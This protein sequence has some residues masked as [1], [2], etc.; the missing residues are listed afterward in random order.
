MHSTAQHNTAQPS[1]AQ[2]SPAQHQRQ[3][4]RGGS[5]VL[6]G[7]G[8]KV[9]L[10][11]VAQ[12]VDGPM[13][14]G[15]PRGRPGG[16]LRSPES[17]KSRSWLPATSMTGAFVASTSNWSIN[18]SHIVSSPLHCQSIASSKAHIVTFWHQLF[19]A[20]TQEHN[21]HQTGGGQSRT[22]ES[23]VT[24]AVH[25]TDRKEKHFARRQWWKKSQKLVAVSSDGS[26]CSIAITRGT[27]L[28]R[29]QLRRQAAR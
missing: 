19:N 15:V 1:P 17:G 6:R 7:T 21:P 22:L 26:H 27:M 14:E 13:V 16:A 29:V 4:R 18:T 20:A 9:Q 24:A 25:L 23:S 5:Q 12:E 28:E 11:G 2:P 10:S 3:R 8:G